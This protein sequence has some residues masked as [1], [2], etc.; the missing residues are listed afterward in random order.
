[1]ARRS[2]LTLTASSAVALLIGAWAAGGLRPALRPEPRRPGSPIDLGRYEVRVTD[3]VLH[4]PAERL[5]TLDVTL[6][7]RSKDTRSVLLQDFAANALTLDVAGGP[8]VTAVGVR[9]V[10]QGADVNMLHPDESITVILTYATRHAAVPPPG[11]HARLS[12]W[13]YDHREDFFY[14]HTQWKPRKPAEAADHEPPGY[15]V[16]LLIRREGV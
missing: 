6:R 3:A 8:P 11:F 13:R 9:G 2:L 15:T 14:G 12:F 1:M 5:V 4:R 16:A 7:L 10:S